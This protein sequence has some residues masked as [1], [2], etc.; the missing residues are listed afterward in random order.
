MIAKAYEQAGASCISVLTDERYFQGSR[1]YLEQ[2]KASSKLP[3]LRKDFL[4][5]ILQVQEARAMGAD[6]ILLIVSALINDG[7]KMAD[8]EAMAHELGM[9]VLVEIHDE[10]ELL[11][12]LTLKTPL[13]GVNNRNL[14]TFEVDLNNSLRLYKELKKQDPSRIMVSESGIHTANDVQQLRE[15]GIFTFLVGESLMRERDIVKAYQRLF[16]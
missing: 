3:I 8:M 2:A 7:S 11:H 15:A 13:I 4:I 9:D 12:A 16:S 1:F 6:A 5:D 10:K 14:K